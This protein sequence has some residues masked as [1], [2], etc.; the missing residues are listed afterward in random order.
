MEENSQTPV[1]RAR[2]IVR[3]KHSVPSLILP[4]Q[5]DMHGKVGR[6]AFRNVVAKRRKIELF[7]HRLSALGVVPDRRELSQK[8]KH[9]R[10]QQRMVE[11]VEMV[12]AR[13]E[14]QLRGRAPAS[15]AVVVGTA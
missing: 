3:S 15:E 1:V 13:N 14:E 8:S 10:R 4:S 2:D 9:A 11:D 5:N 7:E 6:L 12:G